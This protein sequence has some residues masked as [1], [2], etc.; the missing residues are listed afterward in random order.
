MHEMGIAFL[1]WSPLGGISKAGEL[2]SSFA[3]FQEVA[4]ARGVSPQQVTLAW[5]LP[6]SPVVIPIP[7]S[8]RARDR[9]RLGR[10]G[11]AGAERRGDAAAL[12]RRLSPAP[13]GAVRRPAAGGPGGTT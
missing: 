8:S 10:R 2:G 5:M 1:P 9:A 7:G 6:T 11:R 4:D 13:H 3:P 12:R